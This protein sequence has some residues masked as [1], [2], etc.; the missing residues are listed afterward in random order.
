MVEKPSQCTWCGGPLGGCECGGGQ[1]MDHFKAYIPGLIARVFEIWGERGMPS[2]G[3]TDAAR[4]ASLG[5]SRTRY[6][7]ADRAGK[8]RNKDP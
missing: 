3:R 1:A 8:D 7:F 4:L 5:T 6:L 2:C